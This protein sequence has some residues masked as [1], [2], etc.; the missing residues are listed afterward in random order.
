MK[1]MKSSI[2]EFILVIHA[3]WSVLFNG[4]Y[5]TM[6]GLIGNI[7]VIIQIF[8]DGGSLRN[9]PLISKTWYHMHIES[10]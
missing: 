10:S 3:S 9:I 2:V 5:L 1:Y 4:E 6:G 7:P 8:D